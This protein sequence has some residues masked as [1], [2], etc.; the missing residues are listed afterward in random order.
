MEKSKKTILQKTLINEI[1]RTRELAFKRRRTAKFFRG[2]SRSAQGDRKYHENMAD[3]A[4]SAFEDLLAF[5]KELA[6]FPESASQKAF[7]GSYITIKYQDGETQEFYFLDRS[8]RLPGLQ[9][10]SPSS[11]LGQAIKG[12]KA[13]EGF[14]YQVER[15]DRCLSFTGTITKI[16]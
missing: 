12:K 7:P 10:L 9:I 14:D 1:S 3:L 16:E 2:A 4:E 15:D 13:G 8:I 5:E 6:S 11:P